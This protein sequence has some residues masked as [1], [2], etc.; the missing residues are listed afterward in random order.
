MAKFELVGMYFTLFNTRSKL[1]GKIYYFESLFFGLPA[2]SFER[3]LRLV[4]NDS[5]I[6]KLAACEL[7][8]ESGCFS[9]F[10]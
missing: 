10:I 6:L 7:F 8:V 4:K 9:G 3:G 5:E 1:A 2:G